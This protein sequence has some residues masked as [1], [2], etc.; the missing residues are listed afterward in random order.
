MGC[1]RQAGQA[2]DYKDLV[3][4][5]VFSADGT[6]VIA[7]ARDGVITSWDVGSG[8]AAFSIP[9]HKESA[10]NLGTSPTGDCI[11]SAGQ[12][13]AVRVWNA[14]TG[15]AV[16]S[17]KHGGAVW[18]ARFAPDG[19]SVASASF[20]K[21]VKL[22][23][24]KTGKNL[25][26]FKGHTKE[27]LA[28]DFSPDGKTL[29]SG[30]NDRTLRIWNVSTGALVKELP[31]SDIVNSVAFHPDGKTLAVAIGDPAEATPRPA[32]IAIYDTATWTPR[33]HLEASCGFLFNL[34]FRVDGAKVA[35][36]CSD[37]SA[38]IWPAK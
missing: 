10:W 15:A 8:K 31:Q 28:V 16:V 34:A 27:V 14:S 17:M 19:K 12:D 30:G 36:S 2:I 32:T 22:W 1:R 38:R 13:G 9:A 18:L 24:T 4:S 35:A 5:V 3:E 23:D 21:T 6:H 11:V 25:R 26:T 37:G 7:S 33:A 20:D 29:A